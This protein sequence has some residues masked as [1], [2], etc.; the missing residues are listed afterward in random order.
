[1]PRQSFQ[2]LFMAV[3]LCC[4]SVLAAEDGVGPPRFDTEVMAVLSKAGCNAGAC[5]GN[6]SGKGGFRLS[7]RGQDPQLDHRRLTRGAAGRRIDRG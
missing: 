4:G 2:S 6:A 7:L 3:L 1:M 5:H